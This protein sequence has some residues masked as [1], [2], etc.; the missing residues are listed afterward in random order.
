M[1]DGVAE[2][3][4]AGMLEPYLDACG[5]Q[6]TGRGL[7]HVDAQDL[8]EYVTAL[9]AQRFQV[10]LHAIGDRAVRESLDAIAAARA[11]NAMRQTAGTTTGITSPICR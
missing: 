9:D 5:C 10:H 6:T 3:F 1:Q 4:T 8:R 11:A 7:S 2:S